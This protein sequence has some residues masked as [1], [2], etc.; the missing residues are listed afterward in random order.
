MKS[1]IINF[2]DERKKRLAAKQSPL[3]ERKIVPHPAYSGNFQSNTDQMAVIR[4]QI[5]EWQYFGLLLEEERRQVISEGEILIQGGKE[6][7]R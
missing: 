4:T 3:V 7:I 1:E 2:L 5:L 6:S